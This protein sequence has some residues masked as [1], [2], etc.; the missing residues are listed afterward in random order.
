MRA[1]TLLAVLLSIGAARVAAQYVP[2]TMRRSCIS[3]VFLSLGGQAEGGGWISLNEIRE[4]A[5]GS[6]LLS[7]DLSDHNMDWA[8]TGQG[9][10][11]FHAQTGITLREDRARGTSTKF[12]AG[13]GFAQFFSPTITLRRSNYFP[14]DTLISSGTGEYTYLDSVSTSRYHIDHS[15]QRIGV[16]LAMLF[17]KDFP[18]HWMLYGG[19]GATAGITLGGV[20]EIEHVT[21]NYVE[22]TWQENYHDGVRY[23]VDQERIRTDGSFFVNAHLPLGVGYRLAKRHPFWRSLLLT[24]EMQPALTIGGVPTNAEHVRA[25]FNFLFGLRVD[26]DQ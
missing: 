18:G 12:R 2:D 7:S 24:M 15:H 22:G 5:P 19:V 26:L 10:F 20:T 21:E 23:K 14:Y 6:E 17:V 3:D 9:A 8:Q 16:D 11:A 4:S 13:V 25:G 1:L